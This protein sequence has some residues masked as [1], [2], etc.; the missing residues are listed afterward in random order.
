MNE[1]RECLDLYKML[2]QHFP[3]GTKPTEDNELLIP[4]QTD[5]TD[6][7]GPVPGKTAANI[8][9]TGQCSVPE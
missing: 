2:S 4:G 7:K 6:R 8:H 9:G 5:S 3:A 1:P